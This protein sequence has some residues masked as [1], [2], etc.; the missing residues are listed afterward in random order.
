MPNRPDQHRELPLDPD[1]PPLHVRTSSIAL[2]A[3]GG[4]LGTW[5][6]YLV[7]LGLPS[8]DG[9]WPWGTFVVNL[10]GAFVLGLLLEE[11]ARRGPDVGLRQRLRLLGGTGFCGGLTTYSAFAS[12]ADLLVRDSAVGLALGYLATTLVAGA[13]CTWAGIAV[14]TTRTSR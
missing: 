13:A 8:G 3:V 1:T 6:R 4:A 14:A 5:L 12:E 9:R 10:A 11:L 7:S 2:V